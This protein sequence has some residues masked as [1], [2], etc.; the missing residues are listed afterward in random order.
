M[1]LFDSL[2]S[3]TSKEFTT[4]GRLS[5]AAF[6][7]FLL[8]EC[9]TG[10]GFA[11]GSWVFV[12]LLLLPLFGARG[13]VAFSSGFLHG[14]VFVL[15]S[16]Y[17]IAIV[18]EVH[19]GLSH[20]GGIGVLLLI[21]LAW[22]VLTGLFAW[23][24]NFISRRSI[25]RA[26]IA[27]PFL[28]VAFEF[29][30][31]HLPEIGFPWNLLGYPAAANLALVQL[32]AVTGIY[33]LS[34]VVAGFNALSAWTVSAAPAGY[35]RRCSVLL[36]A[37][38]VLV[39]IAWLGPRFV[40]EARAGHFARAVQLNFPE[41]E[42]YES[43]WFRLHA[44]ELDEIERLSVAP[45]DKTPD[46]IV[47]PEAPAPFSF[48]DPQ[49]ARRASALAVRS[50]MPFLAGDIEW[51]PLAVSEGQSGQTRMAPY[52]SAI[53]VDRQGQRVFEY[54]KIH[55]VPYGEYEPFPLIHRVVTNVSNEVGGFTPGSN[56]AV[57]TLAN[58][59]RFS[60]FICY[61]AIFAGEIRRFAAKGAQVFFNLSNDGWFGRSA[62]PAQHLAMARVR[63]VENRR[64][65]VRSTNNGYTVS[66]D[67]YGRIVAR[68]APDVRA[69]VDLPYDFRTD[70]T[71]YT[72]LGDW[73]AWLCVIVSA[74]L[75]MFALASR[76]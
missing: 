27:A 6:S 73:F 37:V 30:R 8:A 69:S 3:S 22:G 74:L 29:V 72:R 24:V 76:K 39:A 48:E 66:V 56:V 75:P 9:Y 51:K 11:I 53:L 64:W 61:E 40:P 25:A 33:G 23:C 70:E 46:I 45:P 21:A 42:S 50:G 58:G 26:C 31:A 41:A 68:L 20:L 43:D 2:Y 14:L 57:G 17:W 55:L 32:T 13:R 67:P 63:A 1:A 28:W 60:V 44:A 35:W 12:M 16:L 71:L 62:A 4:I 10:I 59:H 38:I 7:G 49:F 5:L 34:F 54:D 18:L 52:N 36:G 15:T 19:G 65:L 47:W